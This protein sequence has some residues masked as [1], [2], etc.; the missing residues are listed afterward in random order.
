MAQLRE[1]G[2]QWRGCDPGTNGSNFALRPIDLLCHPRLHALRHTIH[3]PNAAPVYHPT[4]PHW[5]EENEELV[6]FRRHVN[7]TFPDVDIP[8]YVILPKDIQHTRT[9]R[10]VL[11]YSYFLVGVGR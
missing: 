11:V 4:T 5:I 3:D 2:C 1:R 7:H 10:G 6:Y 9:K 8:S